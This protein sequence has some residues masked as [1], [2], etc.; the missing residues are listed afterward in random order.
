MINWV[1]KDNLRQP[2]F[3]IR[4]LY[5]SYGNCAT[6]KLP[7]KW[8]GPSR[9]ALDSPCLKN[10]P[11]NMSK[12]NNKESNV[13]KLCA[14]FHLLHPFVSVTFFFVTFCLW[15]FV[16]SCTNKTPSSYCM[17]RLFTIDIVMNYS[18]GSCVKSLESSDRK[19]IWPAVRPTVLWQC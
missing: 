9:L 19:T 1:C 14:L 16:F 18:Q 3:P 5:I 2:R 8:A 7:I 17:P 6:T 11:L 12:R 4:G 13:C 15:H 10:V